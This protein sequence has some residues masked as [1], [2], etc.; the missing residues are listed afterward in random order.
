MNNQRTYTLSD[1]LHGPGVMDS[2]KKQFVRNVYQVILADF[3]TDQS[4]VT[5][6]AVEKSMQEHSALDVASTISAL[7]KHDNEVPQILADC[8]RI[9]LFASWDYNGCSS[10]Y[11]FKNLKLDWEPWQIKDQT[12]LSKLLAS[13]PTKDMFSFCTGYVYFAY[14]ED[15]MA[16]MVKT[17][18]SFYG[19]G[20]QAK[21]IIPATKN[22]DRK[23]LI[24]CCTHCGKTTSEAQ[25]QREC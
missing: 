18:T 11:V 1:Y 22:E 15:A 8:M 21:E 16:T 14:G 13:L 7:K 24:C 20:E 9:H 10:D 12:S 19:H 17:L 4:P 5:W 25:R 2:A 3:I 23:I 6:Y